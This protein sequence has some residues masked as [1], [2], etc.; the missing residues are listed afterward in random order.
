MPFEYQ[1]VKTN[2]NKSITMD[3][4]QPIVFFVP[5][6]AY[7]SLKFNGN[8]DHHVQELGLRLSTNQPSPTQLMITI[9][10]TL[11]DKGGKTIDNAES[12]V[13]VVVL[14]WVGTNPGTIQLAA[15]S[16]IANHSQ[17]QPI[18]LPSSSLATL[19]TVLAGFNL[20]YGNTDHH[21]LYQ[22]A[23]VAAEQSGATG[24]ILGT[25]KMADS[26]GNNAS[27]GTVNGG[28]IAVASGTDPGVG[29][30]I[31]PNN[32]SSSP[33]YVQ[34]PKTLSAAAVMLVHEHAEYKSVDHHVLTVGAGC[35]GWSVNGKTVQLN[36]AR[37]FMSDSSNSRQDDS[38]SGVTLL[39]VGFYA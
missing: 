39:I 38:K 12:T 20:S 10:G 24:Y 26:S 7:Y 29:F 6:I 5:C 16:N 34:F 35:S 11:R 19:Q 21:V 36:D 32:Q 3:F 31:S 18:P 14:A 28:L 9:T 33:I 1:T 25:V 13:T 37:A 27:T 17:S 30:M 2:P 22:G 8:T 23:G 4:S 15:A